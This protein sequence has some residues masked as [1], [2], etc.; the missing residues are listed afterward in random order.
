MFCSVFPGRVIHSTHS[1]ERHRIAF[2]TIVNSVRQE[3]IRTVIKWQKC[4]PVITVAKTL[5]RRAAARRIRCTLVAR[6]ASGHKSWCDNT[7]FVRTYIGP[8][9]STASGDNIP[10]TSTASSRGQGTVN[11]HPSTSS[12]EPNSDRPKTVKSSGVYEL[13]H[14]IQFEFR[15][16]VDKFSVN[17]GDHDRPI[18]PFPLR[19]NAIDAFIAHGKPLCLLMAYGKQM[20]R[21]LTLVSKDDKPIASFSFDGTMVLVGN[22]IRVHA[23]GNYSANVN[24]YN[25]ISEGKGCKIKID[26][27]DG[28]FDLRI[29][30]WNDWIYFKVF[31]D[32]GPMII[33]A[34]S[35]A[36]NNQPTPS[37]PSARREN[38]IAGVGIDQVTIFC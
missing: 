21:T 5:I 16:V 7:Q 14:I 38:R 20:K 17:E 2:S 31:I 32:F 26:N 11:D 4:Q 22:R 37:S 23:N 1:T 10:S 36:A 34:Q 6:F 24:T 27:I 28:S 25:S 19:I 13:N 15:N 9:T 35:R 30:P 12:S 33:D 8:S 3:R 29:K 18:K